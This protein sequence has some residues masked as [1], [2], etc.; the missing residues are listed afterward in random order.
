MR[1]CALSGDITKSISERNIE[2]TPLTPPLWHLLRVEKS[3]DMAATE[4]HI[5]PVDVAG[6][7]PPDA[8][9]PVQKVRTLEG[10]K[11]S[12]ARNTTRTCRAALACAFVSCCCFM[13]IQ[14]SYQQEW[15]ERHPELRHASKVTIGII[16]ASLSTLALGQNG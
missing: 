2:T 10:E 6:N 7:S 11:Q 9:F 15:E 8:Y 3:A 13:S 5:R 12:K 14:P 16:R 1:S 4:L